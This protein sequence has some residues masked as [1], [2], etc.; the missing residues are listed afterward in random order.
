M[1]KILFGKE[2]LLSVTII[3]FFKKRVK[4]IFFTRLVVAFLKGKTEQIYDNFFQGDILCGK[5]ILEV[6]HIFSTEDLKLD[7][8]RLINT[9]H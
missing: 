7:I 3:A 6:F 4:H 8:L 9:N 2:L 1:G 5:I